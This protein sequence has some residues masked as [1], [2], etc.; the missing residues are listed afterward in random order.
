M[1]LRNINYAI[2]CYVKIADST[3]LRFHVPG[4]YHV[5]IGSILSVYTVKPCD[6]CN[7]IM[8]EQILMPKIIVS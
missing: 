1:N 7:P 8:G 4:F 3:T 6:V 5:Q 2:F